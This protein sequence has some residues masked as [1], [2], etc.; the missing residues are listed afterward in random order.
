MNIY[1]LIRRVETVTQSERE[2][3][4]ERESALAEFGRE[5]RIENEGTERAS[6][7]CNWQRSSSGPAQST[8]G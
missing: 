1:W 5:P 4:R 8:C 2:R 7:D 3:E 6:T